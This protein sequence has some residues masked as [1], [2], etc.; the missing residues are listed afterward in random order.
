MKELLKYDKIN[1]TDGTAMMRIK[2]INI[3]KIL[4]VLCLILCTVV[5]LSAC[6]DEE[7]AKQSQG[8]SEAKAH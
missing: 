3:W 7:N 4:K 5:L 8:E 1:V 6:G 2:D